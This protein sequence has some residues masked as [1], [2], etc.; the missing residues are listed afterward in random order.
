[1]AMKTKAMVFSALT[2]WAVH[3]TFAKPM[4]LLPERIF[5]T[6]TTF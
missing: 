3:A 5:A 2:A 1:M 4:F 6:L